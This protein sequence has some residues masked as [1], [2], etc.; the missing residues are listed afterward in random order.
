VQGYRV[1]LPEERLE[2]DFNDD[3]TLVLNPDI[4]G[5]SITHNQGIIGEGVDLNLKHLG[6][7]RYSTLVMN[8]TKRLLYTKWRDEGEQPKLYLFP[9][10]SRIVKQWLDK[11]LVCVGG[12]YAAQLMYQELADIACARITD[13]ITRKMEK[14]TPIRAILDPYNPEGSSRHINFRTTKTDR[15]ET[16]ADRCHVNWVI[17]DSDWESEFCRVAEANPRV[18]SYVKNHAMG[19]EVPYRVG[20]ANRI[21]R[22]DFIVR[23][24]DG[25]GED[26]LLNLVVEIKGY[27]GEDAKDKKTTMATYWVPAINRSGKHGRWAFAEFTSVYA[28]ESEFAKEIEGRFDSLLGSFLPPGIAEI[29]RRVYSQLGKDRKWSAIAD[30]VWNRVLQS[31]EHAIALAD[32]HDASNS[33]EASSTDAL[34]VI[35][36]LSSTA[37]PLLRMELHRIDSPKESV[38]PA[39]LFSKLRQWWREKTISDDEWK[40]WASSVQVRWVQAAPEVE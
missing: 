32:L 3:S 5:P 25:H 6:D 2:A 33:A 21:Y 11:H 10:L 24:E 29:D 9:Q 26:D 7:M 35:S 4:V 28:I 40:S 38:N 15:W 19:F 18:R 36:V 8:L 31:P 39:E 30:A 17:L 34:A 37:R 23:V 16:R 12:T 20:A 13:G 22:P 14:E 27:R 1:E